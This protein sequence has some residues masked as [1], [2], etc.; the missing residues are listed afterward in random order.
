MKEVPCTF[1]VDFITSNKELFDTTQLH[2]IFDFITS[3]KETQREKENI[4]DP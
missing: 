4:W 3:I 1:N 2:F